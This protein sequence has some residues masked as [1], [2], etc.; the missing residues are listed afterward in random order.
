MNSIPKPMDMVRIEG[1][2]M[3]A[4]VLEIVYR[5]DPTSKT[6]APHALLFTEEGHVVQALVDALRPAPYRSPVL[7]CTR[8]EW[9]GGAA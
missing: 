3:F 2:V 8:I 1:S 9:N 6:K 5:Y 7:T 4:Q